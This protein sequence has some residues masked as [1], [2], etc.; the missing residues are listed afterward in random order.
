MFE[1]TTLA[2]LAGMIDGD[3]YITINRSKRGPY[4]YH[5]PQIGIAGTRRE[6]H[7]LAASIWGGSV[8]CF[9]PTN[10]RHRAQFQ[11]TRQGAVAVAA[12]EALK[13]YLRIKLQH[14]E[15]ALELWAHLEEGRAEDPFPWFSPNYEPI[16]ARD[17]MRAEMIGLNQSRNRLRRQEAGRLLDGIEHNGF[18]EARCET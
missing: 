17:A 16:Q 12:I 13:P 5:G 8:G 3:G 7:D 6:P 4:V 10:P 9:R 18:P 15:L 2:Y 14:A 11:W 1:P